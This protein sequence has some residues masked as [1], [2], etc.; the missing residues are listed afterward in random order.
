MTDRNRLEIRRRAAIYVLAGLALATT[1]GLVQGR[2]LTVP[3]TVHLT[4]ELSG[5]VVAGFAGVIAVVRH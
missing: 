5:M 2:G 3:L 4:V 1:V